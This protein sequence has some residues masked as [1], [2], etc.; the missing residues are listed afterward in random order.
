[1]RLESPVMQRRKKRS[2]TLERTLNL[3]TPF[4]N[5][6]Y[7]LWDFTW[8]SLSWIE[9]VRFYYCLI[10]HN[11]SRFRVDRDPC[12]MSFSV[13]HWYYW[14]R[15]RP[16]LV[17]SS[18]KPPWMKASFVHPSLLQSL[19]LPLHQELYFSSHILTNSPSKGW[20][21][22]PSLLYRLWP[23][24]QSG[25]IHTPPMAMAP[26]FHPSG[27]YSSYSFVGFESQLF[28]YWRYL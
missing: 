3:S 6:K 23:L 1:M 10:D 19:P 5:R 22:H 13:I 14:L 18:N 17:S 7:M 20:H 25:L 24:I 16:C 2:H 21:L 26:I 15:L 4:R 28:I 12:Y 11:P 9:D 8:L 27:A